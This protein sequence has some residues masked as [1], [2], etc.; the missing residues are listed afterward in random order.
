MELI[1]DLK[2]RTFAFST[3]TVT[4]LYAIN[5]ILLPVVAIFWLDSPVNVT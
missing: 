3:N 5:L 2:L 1:S 4:A